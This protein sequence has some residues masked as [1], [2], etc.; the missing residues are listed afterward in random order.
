MGDRYV[1]FTNQICELVGREFPSKYIIYLAYAA[2]EAPPRTVKPHPRLLPVLTTPG[3][4]YG[5]W[6]AWMQTGPSNMGLYLHHDDVFFILP[7]LDVH[8]N[9]R[10]LRYIVASGQA[11]VFYMETALSWPFDD[12]LPYVLGELLW[13]PRQDVDALL[14]EYF[15]QFYGAAA[16]PMRAFHQAVESGCERW[17]AEEGVPH[18]YGKDISSS[19]HSRALEQFR[20]LTPEEAAR[21]SADLTQA[22]AA[23]GQDEKIAQRIRIIAA[24]FHLQEL[25]VQWAWAAF[26][27]RVAAPHSEAEARHVADDARLIFARSHEM[28]RYFDEVLEQ[29][30]LKTYRLFGRSA[31]SL[32]LL[33]QLKSGE[34]G[35]EMM[36]AISTGVTAAGEYLRAE[37][38][39][40]K[41]AAWWRALAEREA[42]PALAAVFQSAARRAAGQEAKNLLSDPGFE[43]IGRELAPN[44]FALERDVLLEPAQTERLGLHLWFPERTPYRC[45][46]TEAG[47]HSGR[48]AL[49]LE[50]LYRARFTRSLAVKPG[51]R[52][53]VGFWFKQNEGAAKYRLEVDARLK[54]GS[55]PSLAKLPVSAPAGAWRE[56]ATEV[57]APP[58]ATTV[59]LRLYIDRQEAGAQCW[60]DDLFIGR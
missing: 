16:G 50:H 14:D 2:A 44:E 33:D 53:Q 19:R 11:R 7:K 3:N 17:L 58:G 27:L 6:D 55:Y 5:Q 23:A 28:K 20:V 36:G 26:R 24:Q 54:D 47:A 41:A 57:V 9:A 15:R 32:T 46:L 12:T 31:R 10:R 56:F 37:L 59:L 42:E 52:L 4:M 1:K 21:A 60:I 38:G 51:E 35:S 29:P 30:P 43:E 8:Q 18:P 34:P 25:A 48:Y 22:A 39:G 49:R 13:D 45:H 40:E